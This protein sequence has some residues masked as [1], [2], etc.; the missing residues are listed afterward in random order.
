MVHRPTNTCTFFNN[1]LL[2]KIV[3]ILVLTCFFFN[4]AITFDS[5]TLK[6]AIV[7]H[8]KDFFSKN[9]FVFK[10]SQFLHYLN[11]KKWKIWRITKKIPN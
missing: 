6:K 2:E 1:V 7:S 8:L 10:K 5:D 11:P 9:K 4:F 3:Q